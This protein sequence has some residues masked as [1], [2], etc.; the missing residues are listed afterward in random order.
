[1]TTRLEQAFIEASKLPPQDQDSL[2][3]WLLTELESE[4]RWEKLFADSQDILSK[5]ADEALAE[6]RSG[7]T[8][9]LHPEQ[10]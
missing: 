6:H 1:M 9:D 2:A 5:L 10:I 4:R 7:Q 8:Q 3:G